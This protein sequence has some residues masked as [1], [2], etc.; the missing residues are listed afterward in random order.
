MIILKIFE[1]LW[2]TGPVLARV[3]GP[4]NSKL[5]GGGAKG[6]AWYG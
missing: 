6:L 5:W 4:D 2:K 3:N 1:K